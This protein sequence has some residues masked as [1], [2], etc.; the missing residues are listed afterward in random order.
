MRAFLLVCGFVVASA[1]GAPARA[2]DAFDPAEAIALLDV[3]EATLTGRPGASR[4]P[5]ASAGKPRL[6]GRPKTERVYAAKEIVYLYPYTAY[7]RGLVEQYGSNPVRLQLQLTAVGDYTA[8]TLT[9]ADGRFSFRGLRPGRYVLLTAVPYEAKV[10]I[11]EDTGRTRTETTFS[12]GFGY[13]AGA[14]SVTSPIYRYRS[15][16]SELEHRIVK[17][18]DVTG[19]GVTDLGEI[20]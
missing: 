20:E 14:S 5:P 18:V 9:D 4:I 12:G 16:T 3:G 6:L 13:T 10:T 8:R 2:A 15:A 19:T 11:R 17:V 7:V 1:P